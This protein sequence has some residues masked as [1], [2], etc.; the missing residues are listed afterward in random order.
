MEDRI[1]LGVSL[2]ARVT[3]C[4]PADLAQGVAL[5]VVPDNQVRDRATRV[6][7]KVEAHKVDLDQDN[8]LVDHRVSLPLQVVVALR[9]ER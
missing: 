5:E 9:E 2:V 7:V 3:K 4:T 6:V 1:P 8:R